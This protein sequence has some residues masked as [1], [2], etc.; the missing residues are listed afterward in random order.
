MR[1]TPTVKAGDVLLLEDNR[2][3]T[4][5][6][7]ERDRIAEDEYNY[8]YSFRNFYAV[9]VTFDGEKEDKFDH[10]NWRKLE[11]RSI[12]DPNLK[13]GDVVEIKPDEE[14]KAELERN[15]RGRIIKIEKE[16]PLR[17]YVIRSEDG[18]TELCFNRNEFVKVLSATSY[19][20]RGETISTLNTE[21]KRLDDEINSLTAQRDAL[22]VAREVMDYVVT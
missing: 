12:F 13:V 14:F 8:G 17:P 6:R 18:S 10:W 5:V 2:I 1:D 3:C 22:K 7:I 4:V 20:K 16:N 9:I 11:N 21:I 15:P 19:E